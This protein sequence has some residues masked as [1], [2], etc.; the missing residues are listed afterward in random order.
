MYFEYTS[1]PRVNIHGDNTNFEMFAFDVS[2]EM[3][4]LFYSTKFTEIKRV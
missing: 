3:L 4:I 1:F 2:G